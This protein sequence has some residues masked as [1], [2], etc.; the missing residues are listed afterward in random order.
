VIGL[1]RNAD[2]LEV[3]VDGEAVEYSVLSSYE[4]P[5]LK[6]V[7]IH[8]I[9]LPSQARHTFSVVCQAGDFVP[10]TYQG[11]TSAYLYED[12]ESPAGTILGNPY[13]IDYVEPKLVVEA[14]TVD[15]GMIKTSAIGMLFDGQSDG[16]LLKVTDTRR[17]KPALRL[18]LSQR[19]Q[20]E[21]E[22]GYLDADLYFET[23]QGGA[24]ALLSNNE[25]LVQESKAGELLQSVT[26][27]PLKFKLRGLSA[28]PGQYQS[29]LD[30][31][32]VNAPS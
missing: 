14:N 24:L 20:F 25:T 29:E 30:W 32:I 19:T 26:G 6:T 5:R 27:Q 7:M 23:I 22:N 31:T 15:F 21:N 12:P 8:N 28:K 2:I 17:N 3:L 10:W 1:D 4:E 16:A 9:A 18:Y 11:Q 13:T